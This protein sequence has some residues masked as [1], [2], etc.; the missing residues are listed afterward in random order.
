MVNAITLVNSTLY[1]TVVVVLVLVSWMENKALNQQQVSLFAY[2]QENS[3]SKEQTVRLV[4]DDFSFG[5]LV[6]S[7]AFI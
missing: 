3:A 1:S 7:A 6:V 4:D 5:G 2:F